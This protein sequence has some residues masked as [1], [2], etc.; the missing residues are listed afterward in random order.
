MLPSHGETSNHLASGHTPRTTKQA[1]L[2]NS[3]NRD[4]RDDKIEPALYSGPAH[5]TNK[6]NSF[7]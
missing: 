1:G 4:A 7:K 6:V 5:K 2:I 3:K